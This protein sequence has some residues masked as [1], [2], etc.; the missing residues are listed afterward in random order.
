[1]SL[2][3]VVPC[4]DCSPTLLKALQSV[5]ALGLEDLE[6]IVI[7]DGSRTREALRIQEISESVPRVKLVRHANQGLGGTRNRGIRE[8]TREYLYFLDAD[9]FVDPRKLNRVLGVAHKKGLDL[10]LFDTRP[11]LHE[12]DFNPNYLK[13]RKDYYRRNHRS[14]RDVRSGE[15]LA[16]A[17][18]EHNNY[19]PSA[20]LYLV[21]RE[22]L[23]SSG[24]FF[25][26]RGLFEDL[27]FTFKAIS[28]AKRVQ[29]FP[30]KAHFRS[31]RS[32]S[33][34]HSSHR[35][36]RIAGLRAA[37]DDIEDFSIA[38]WGNQPP[39]YA[40]QLLDR[41]SNRLQNLYGQDLRA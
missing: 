20:C 7:D 5:T 26:P 40:T 14:P 24:I 36:E 33:L 39:R 31:L 2:T 6:V 12:A 21:R 32:Q 28:T 11:F 19:L 38:K 29:Y 9:D 3:V 41:Y 10:A 23:L 22:F 34:T 17:L 30:V 1:M 18:V 4:L 25:R 37:I 16:Q 27:A 8:A 13:N 15:A 35:E